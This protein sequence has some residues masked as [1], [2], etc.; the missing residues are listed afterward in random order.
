MSKELTDQIKAVM[1]SELK[2][3]RKENKLLK[4]KVADLELQIRELERKVK[5]E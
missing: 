5:G 1:D 4:D 3:M 2:H